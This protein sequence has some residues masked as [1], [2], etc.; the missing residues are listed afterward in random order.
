[1]EKAPIGITLTDPNQPDNPMVY[2]NQRFCEMTGYEESE[3]RDRNCR[4]MQGPETDPEPV[5]EIRNAI[6]NEE[7]AT[8]VHRN[9]RK[10]GTMFRNRLTIAPVR[11]T[12]GEVSNWVGFQ[13]DV[14]ER[15]EREQQP[16]LAETG[17]E[18][19]QDALFIC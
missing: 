19:T 18:N 11:N 17:F 4:F 10:H 14:S 3:I 15:I 2:A 1:M 13:A 6:D 12:D 9:Y 7:P 8:T 16:E 5:A